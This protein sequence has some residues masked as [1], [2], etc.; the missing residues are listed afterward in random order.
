MQGRQIQVSHC[1]RA[2]TCYFLS[3]RVLVHSRGT[4]TLLEP[5]SCFGDRPLKFQVDCPLNGTAD[6]KGLNWKVFGNLD[7]QVSLKT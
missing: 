1:T 4:L 6:L 2:R 7:F 5:Q 3:V